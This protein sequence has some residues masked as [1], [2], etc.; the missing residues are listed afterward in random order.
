MAA[1]PSTA[2]WLLLGLL[3]T[4]NSED[5]DLGNASEKGISSSAPSCS[6]HGPGDTDPVKVA[7]DTT[8][9]AKEITYHKGRE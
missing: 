7:H 9:V 3:G 5:K 6:T 4:R 8:A 2:P 1:V